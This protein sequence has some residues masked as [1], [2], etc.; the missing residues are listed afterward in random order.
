M[1]TA[2]QALD[3]FKRGVLSGPRLKKLGLN[4]HINR[5]LT[6]TTTLLSTDPNV[7]IMGFGIERLSDL[8]WW[9]G[10]VRISNVDGK[11]PFNTW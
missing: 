5:K 7:G 3:E 9:L 10:D 2:L 4:T 1:M 6:P 8:H 11:R